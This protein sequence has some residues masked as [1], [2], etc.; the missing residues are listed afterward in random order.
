MAFL[1]LCWP[2]EDGESPELDP[3]LGLKP[4]E[5][6]AEVW[7]SLE[8]WGL[9]CWATEFSNILW[10]TGKRTKNDIDWWIHRGIEMFALRCPNSKR[11]LFKEYSTENEEMRVL[12]SFEF[13]LFPFKRALHRSCKGQVIRLKLVVI[14]KFNAPFLW[15]IPLRPCQFC[16]VCSFVVKTTASCRQGR[17]EKWQWTQHMKA[18]C[19]CSCAVCTDQG[20]KLTH[21][22]KPQHHKRKQ[23][24]AGSQTA[25]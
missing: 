21:A 23:K 18:R 8:I 11:N 14:L 3:R 7:P 20:Q 10:S 5:R 25:K 13:H 9:C 1:S 4:G 12:I 19:Q 15:R 16:P 22:R 17:T 24:K 6:R 2:P